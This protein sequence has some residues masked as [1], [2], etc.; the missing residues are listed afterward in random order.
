MYLL[1]G[2][3]SGTLDNFFAISFYTYL[4]FFWI[5]IFDALRSADT[6][7]VC[8][9]LPRLLLTTA[10]WLLFVVSNGWILHSEYTDPL[11]DFIQHGVVLKVFFAL[12]GVLMF[13][14]LLYFFVQLFRS[15]SE[16]KTMP[17]YVLR[18]T[19]L[20]IPMLFSAVNFLIIL[21]L[22][23]SPTGSVFFLRAPTYM[24]VNPNS[25][26]EHQ[27][28]FTPSYAAFPAFRS[29][30]E[31]GLS[32]GIAFSFCLLM[33]KAYLPPKTSLA[34]VN[35]KD[36]PS[37]SLACD[38]DEDVMFGSDRDDIQLRRTARNR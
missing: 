16:L 22:R 35:L 13:L 7:C 15:Y 36:D 32:F 6:S 17:Y 8:F 31:L 23:F 26:S 11:F 24:L 4:L 28:P 12:L 33:T 5:S 20:L 25:T 38:S 2:W 37:I 1:P 21:A 27:R 18:L 10:I 30:I 34:E 3:I 29:A 14:Y 19:F 9:Y